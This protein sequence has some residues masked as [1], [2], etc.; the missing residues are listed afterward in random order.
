MAF[1]PEEARALPPPP[2]VN[3]VSAWLGAAG[4]AAALLGNGFSQRPVLTA[5]VHRQVLFATVGW[6]VGY[7]LAKRT[8]YIHAKQDREMFEYIRHH[9]EDFKTAGKKRIGELLEDFI[10][11][12]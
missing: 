2:L 3:K 1:L 8:E 11:N 12:R 7:F 6:V 9:P 5:G 10:P 4:W